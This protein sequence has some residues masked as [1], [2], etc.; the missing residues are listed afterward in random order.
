MD[1]DISYFAIM[2]LIRWRFVLIEESGSAGSNLLRA[3]RVALQV[4][5]I[6]EEIAFACL[7][8]V[9]E[10]NRQALLNIR[11]KDAD[12]ILAWLERKGLLRLPNAQ[13]IGEPTPFARMTLEGGA[14]LAKGLDLDAGTLKAMFS[15]ASALLH[16]RH[17]ERLLEAQVIAEREALESDLQ[18]LRDWL[19]LHVMFLKSKGFLVQMGQ[20]GTPSF[21]TDLTRLSDLPANN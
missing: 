15:R 14:G 17:P 18:R 11:T 3:E 9:E 16:E 8:A 19:W 6:V 4:R 12:A 7:S 2:Q 10:R 21:M 13:R 20:H 1:P 5:K